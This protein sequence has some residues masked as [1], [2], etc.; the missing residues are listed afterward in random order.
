MS[1][2]GKKPVAIPSGVTVQTDGARVAAKGPKGELAVVLPA[3]INAALKDGA[4]TLACS[5]DTAK[6]RSL[7]G[8]SRSLVA[9]MVLGVSQGY[10]KD[11]ELQGVGFRA[12]VQGEKLTMT[13]GYSSPIVFVAPA[14]I[15]I[16]VKDT[17][18]TVSGPD[19][20]KVGDTAARIRSYYPPEP[21]KG[22]GI[23]YKGEHVRRKAGKTV[24]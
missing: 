23:R 5:E 14:G 10:S 6:G 12:A 22:K 9:N 20:Q 4:V 19:K 11:L 18:M 13:I 8:L 16:T 21:Y 17:N 15:T 2:I 1:R 24:A 3:T 7:H